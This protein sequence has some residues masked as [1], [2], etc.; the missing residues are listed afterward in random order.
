[1]ADLIGHPELLLEMRHARGLFVA[2][3]MP[4]LNLE[5]LRY[6]IPL[7]TDFDVVIPRIADNVEPLHTIYSKACLRPILDAL[8][9][10]ELRVIRFFPHVR[11]RYVEQSEIDASDPEHLSFF[12]IIPRMISIWPSDRSSEKLHH[13][14]RRAS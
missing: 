5:L 8:D 3:D 10:G 7:S 4:L 13:A 1:M 6:M 11:V 12:N 2:C 14:G 9:R